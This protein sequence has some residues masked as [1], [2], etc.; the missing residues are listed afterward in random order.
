[1]EVYE[2]PATKYNPHPREGG[3]FSDYI[4]TFLKHKAE[5]RGYPIWV[6]NTEDE[7]RHFEN[8]NAKE[9]VLLNRD[10]IRPNAANRGLAKLCLNSFWGKLAERRN[11]TQTNMISDPQEQFRFLVTPGVEVMN[12]MFASDSVVWATWRYTAE[13]QD[14]SLRHTNEFVDAY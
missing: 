1:M 9:G 5:A 4:N 6:R 7:E 11:Q 13:E 10:S 8:F 2:Y 3:L 12:L 14:P